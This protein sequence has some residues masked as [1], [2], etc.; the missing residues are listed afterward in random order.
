MNTRFSSNHS[1]VFDDSEQFMSTMSSL[2]EG[3]WMSDAN[4][5]VLGA[6]SD[7][8][9]GSGIRST[10]LEVAPTISAMNSALSLI[11]TEP[12]YVS[13][14]PEVFAQGI[15]YDN[16]FLKTYFPL[17][18]ISITDAKIMAKNRLNFRPHDAAPFRTYCAQ[19]LVEMLTVAASAGQGSELGRH[20]M[21][22]ICF[23]MLMV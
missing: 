20:E 18:Y 13:C 23:S 10:F 6:P 5:L 12:S 7:P 22:D 9:S 11:H 19:V 4:S 21:S 15:K 17:A 8:V 2:G 3:H 16:E 1:S 14:V